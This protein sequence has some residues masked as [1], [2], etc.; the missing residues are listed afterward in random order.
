MK[1]LQ[2]SLLLIH[3]NLTKNIKTLEIWGIAQLE[4]ARCPKSDWKYSLGVVTCVK[5][6]V[7]STPLTAKI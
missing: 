1:K 5:I 3:K 2:K 4:A 7:S 6:L